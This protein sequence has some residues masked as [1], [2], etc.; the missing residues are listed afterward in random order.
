MFKL[1]FKAIHHLLTPY[2]GTRVH[3]VKQL[4][5]D[6]DYVACHKNKLIPIDY[7]NIGKVGFFRLIFLC[8]NPAGQN[9][10]HEGL[11]FPNNVEVEISLKI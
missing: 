6:K 2:G 5:M 3:S 4:R 1:D 7:E 8:I 11:F 9:H 10:D